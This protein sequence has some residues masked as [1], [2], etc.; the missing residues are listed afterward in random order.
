MNRR[1]ATRVPAQIPATAV[2]TTGVLSC[3]TIIVD[4][5]SRGLGLLSRELIVPGSTLRITTTVAHTGIPVQGRVVW[6]KR[7][8]RTTHFICGAGICLD[9]IPQISEK[10]LLEY[11][12]ARNT[13]KN[14]N[15]FRQ[16]AEVP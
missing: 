6:V 1:S 16:L 7:I 11:A 13:E 8:K 14:E 10:D 2:D 9:D 4:V 12:H 5:S 3:D 15:L